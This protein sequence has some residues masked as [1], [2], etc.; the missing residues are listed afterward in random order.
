MALL[1]FINSNQEEMT[2][3]EMSRLQSKISSDFMPKSGEGKDHTAH[4]HQR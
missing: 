2:P 3:E 1:Y 4:L